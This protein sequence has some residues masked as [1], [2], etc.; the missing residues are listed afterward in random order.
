MSLEFLCPTRAS[1]KTCIYLIKIVKTRAKRK[2]KR[3][4]HFEILQADNANCSQHLPKHLVIAL[5]HNSDVTGLSKSVPLGPT[6][7]VRTDLFLP[8]TKPTLK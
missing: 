7:S 1:F 4:K 2:H 5:S 3:D 8:R 6:F